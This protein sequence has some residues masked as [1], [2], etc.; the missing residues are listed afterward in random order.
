[1][2]QKTY[3][4]LTFIR[5]DQEQ[6]WHLEKGTKILKDL[7]T[8]LFMYGPYE[9]IYEREDNYGLAEIT[10]KNSVITTLLSEIDDVK[11]CLSSL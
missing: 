1:M 3:H 11:D 9:V 5:K 2:E 7:Q 4:T 10:L 6:T 8:P